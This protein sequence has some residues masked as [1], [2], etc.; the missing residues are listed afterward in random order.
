MANITAE[1]VKSA[2]DEF[3]G[4]NCCYGSQPVQTMILKDICMN[5]AFHVSEFTLIKSFTA[6]FVM[7]INYF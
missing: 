5:S 4:E 1:E 6:V 7:F 2:L 3:V